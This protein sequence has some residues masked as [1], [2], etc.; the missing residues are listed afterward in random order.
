MDLNHQRAGASIGRWLLRVVVTLS[1]GRA[2]SIDPALAASP[3]YG[4]FAE[5]AATPRL[6]ALG[7][8]GVAM[9][10]ATD[11]LWGNPAGMLDARTREAQSS[12]ADLFDLGLVSHSS[13]A[14]IWPLLPRE[15]AWRG[16]SIEAQRGQ[17][18]PGTVIGLGLSSLGS[19]VDV[20]RYDETQFALGLATR[21][22]AEVAIGFTYRFLW[23]QSTIEN[24]GAQG[25]AIDLGLQRPVGPLVFGLAARGFSS[26]INWDRGL[27]EPLA[28]RLQAGVSYAPF[29]GLRAQAAAVWVGDESELVYPSIAAEYTPRREFTLRGALRQH[30]DAVD[31][32][33]EWS[34]GASFA[35]WRL[36]IDYATASSGQE[37]GDTQ[38]IGGSVQF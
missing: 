20:D 17:A 11:A 2:L 25:H 23:A 4:G 38:R 21:G 31:S 10:G 7:G 8:N 18:A 13:A 26:A 9:G 24:F 37:L 32:P 12:Y 22:P 5:I 3:R 1:V 29:A 34:A 27:D 36:R 33:T 6:L 28:R 14:L 19:D 15:I 30:R 16:G 35:I